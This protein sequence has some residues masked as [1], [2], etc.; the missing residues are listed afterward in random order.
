MTLGGD[1]EPQ[2][3]KLMYEEVTLPVLKTHYCETNQFLVVFIISAGKISDVASQ[4]MFM[5]VYIGISC[6]CLMHLCFEWV[7]LTALAHPRPSRPRC[8]RPHEGLRH[9]RMIDVDREDYI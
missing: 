6:V 3:V 9:E 4:L 8:G 1:D 2:R 5:K 7:Q